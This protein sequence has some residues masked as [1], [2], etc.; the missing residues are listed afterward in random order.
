PTPRPIGLLVP[1][2]WEECPPHDRH[3]I[4]AA[5]RRERG[6]RGHLSVASSNAAVQVP[7]RRKGQGTRVVLPFGDPPGRTDPVPAGRGTD[8]PVPGDPGRG[9]TSSP[10]SGTT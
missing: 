7:L 5:H 10:P 2:L 8:H 6:Q 3:R 1:L 9:R 4:K